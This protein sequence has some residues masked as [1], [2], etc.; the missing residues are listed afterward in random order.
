MQQIQKSRQL[1]SMFVKLLGGI[2]DL[3]E[4]T[5]YITLFDITTCNGE[6]CFGF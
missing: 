2:Y 5:L 1:E 3:L 6:D 4:G